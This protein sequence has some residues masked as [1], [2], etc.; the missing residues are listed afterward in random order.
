M[1]EPTTYFVGPST[2]LE[3]G[4][5]CSTTTRSSISRALSKSWGHSEH[6]VL[7]DST[8]HTPMKLVLPDG[9][10]LELFSISLNGHIYPVSLVIIVVFSFPHLENSRT[11]L[12]SL[13]LVHTSLSPLPTSLTQAITAHP[14]PIWP[15]TTHTVS[16]LT[17]PHRQPG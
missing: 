16:Y 14:R 13:R 2:K 9:P 7:C 1:A 17:P 4:V 10:F 8:G 12:V 6:R 11:H 3:C 5:S 15:S